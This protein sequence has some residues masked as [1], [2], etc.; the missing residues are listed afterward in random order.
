MSEHPARTGGHRVAQLTLL[1]CCVLTV[2]FIAI[3]S[4]VSAVGTVIVA[5]VGLA[6]LLVL[7]RYER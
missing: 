7:R 6:S 4:K 3:P 5:V 2:L 1:A